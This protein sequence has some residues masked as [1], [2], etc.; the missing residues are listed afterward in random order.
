MICKYVIALIWLQFH[1]EVLDLM[2]SKYVE[3]LI[4]SIIQGISEFIP[5][6]SSAHLLIISRLSDFNASNLQLD[7]S[8]HLGSLLAIILFFRKELINIINN[9]NIF[10]LII[11]GSI[12]LVIVG[13]IFYSTNLIDQFRNLKVVAWTTLI[14]GIL[15]YF[16]DKF[17][18]KNKISSELNIKSIIIIGLFQILAIIPGVSRSGIVITASRFLKFDRV[19]SSKIAFYLSIPALAGASVLGFKDV[20]DDQI[21]F[22]AIFIFSTLASFLFSYFT[23][24]YFLIYVKMFSLSFFV[25]YRIVLSIILFSV[26]YL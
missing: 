17:E 4:L 16:S 12:P 20:I 14:F 1:Y 22:D 6:S 7:I 10:L 19:E 25:I 9:K 8:L 3:T 23:I 26:I 15:L 18:L 21:N 5:V 11:L 2:I 13:Y 24:K